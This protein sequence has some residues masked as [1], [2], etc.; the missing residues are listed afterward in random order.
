MRPLITRRGHTAPQERGDSPRLGERARHALINGAVAVSTVLGVTAGASAFLTTTAQPA[1]A[2]DPGAALRVAGKTAASAGEAAAPVGEGAAAGAEAGPVGAGVGAAIGVVVVIATGV[3]ALTGG[4]RSAAP[5]KPTG[6]FGGAV[7]APSDDWGNGSWGTDSS[8]GSWGNNPPAAQ[9]SAPVAGAA[10]APTPARGSSTTQRGTSSSSRKPATAV[11]GNT[12]AP[13]AS[14]P[15]TAKRAPAVP[16]L[17]AGTAQDLATLGFRGPNA[18]RNFQRASGLSP[19]GTAG[20]LTR[21]HIGANLAAVRAKAQAAAQAAAAAAQAQVTAAQAQATVAHAQAAAAAQ[22][23]VLAAAPQAQPHATVSASADAQA[24]A[25]AKTLLAAN[26][27]AKGSSAAHG[28]ST[29]M[30]GALQSLTAAEK[31]AI[32]ADAQARV[33]SQE[34][35][36]R[37]SQGRAQLAASSLQNPEPSRHTSGFTL[38]P[39]T[40]KGNQRALQLNLQ[41]SGVYHGAIDGDI[42]D[43]SKHAL[44]TVKWAQHRLGVAEDGN[45][46]PL[47]EAA[48]RAY[49]ARHGLSET[50]TLNRPTLNFMGGAKATVHRA[51]PGNKVLPDA[52][53]VPKGG[54]KGTQVYPPGKALPGHPDGLPVGPAIIQPRKGGGPHRLNVTNSTQSASP[55]IPRG[56][57][58]KTRSDPKNLKPG[59]RLKNSE[60]H[61][62]G[63]GL[64]QGSMIT[65]REQLEALRDSGVAVVVLSAAQYREGELP[66]VPGITT[67]IAPLRADAMT[68]QDAAD[69]EGRVLPQ[70]HAVLSKPENA[71]KLGGAFCRIG[72]DDSGMVN[73]LYMVRYLG[74]TPAD[75]IKRIELTRTPDDIWYRSGA[76]G[77]RP[78]LALNGAVQRDFVLTHKLS[79][80]PGADPLEGGW[81]V[82]DLLAEGF[83]FEADARPVPHVVVKAPIPGD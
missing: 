33:H 61:Y 1:A 62:L 11:R 39:T 34:A 81:N 42:G 26:A 15:V 12:V 32:A 46:G 14:V 49:Q 74:Y 25:A 64:V 28:A 30:T 83:G 41:H 23:Q 58:S 79:E 19:D 63:E 37:T 40:V 29:H 51:V 47:T 44:D 53:P 43:L 3:H 73:A 55:S 71:G 6:D 4:A 31:A 70:M 59:D 20:T 50:G 48:I 69:L 78:I 80:A 36:R 7:S 9:L 65:T 68:A 17:S 38:H 60:A 18:V 2:F 16:A 67:I 52:N 72:Q 76:D 45:P 35:Q 5:A 22:A 27:K 8:A 13:R 54:V 24:K 66:A 21:G 82:N 75:A 56:D 77:K 10:P 57:P